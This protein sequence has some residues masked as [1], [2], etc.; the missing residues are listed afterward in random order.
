MGFQKDS[1][2]RLFILLL[3]ASS[4][5]S[6]AI[7]EGGANKLQQ[8]A[9]SA[10]SRLGASRKVLQAAGSGPCPIEFSQQDLADAAGACTS[11]F[12]QGTAPQ[13]SCCSKT[14]GI[15]G[16]AQAR[17]ANKTGNL[18]VSS[19]VADVCFQTLVVALKGVTVSNAEMLLATCNITTSRISAP[20][21]GTSLV[22]L[23]DFYFAANRSFPDRG[24]I[25][26][27]FRSTNCSACAN[28]KTERFLSLTTSNPE[29]DGLLA[30]A[31]C[32]ELATVAMVASSVPSI[33][34]NGIARCSWGADYAP[35]VQKSTCT[36]TP[37]QILDFSAVRRSC[38]P[39]AYHY[40]RCCHVMIGMLAQ[41]LTYRE[42]SK[43]GP[44]P[45]D[46][47]D[48]CQ[49]SFRDQL[50][51]QGVDPS[52]LDTCQLSGSYFLT[53]QACNEYTFY[54]GATFPSSYLT[55]L[56]AECSPGT[57]NANCTTDLIAMGS[58]LASPD[59]IFACIVYINIKYMAEQANLVEATDRLTC[60]IVLPDP[61]RLGVNETALAELN[62]TALGSLSR[63]GRPVGTK[64]IVALAVGGA[65]VVT[66]LVVVSAWLGLCRKK[67]VLGWSFY[68]QK[69]LS[70]SLSLGGSE[71]Y[72]NSQI[73]VYSYNELKRA[74][75]YFS[76]KRLLG[77]GG[78]GYVYLGD[79]P[80][81][82]GMVAVKKI[83][84]GRTKAG[85][86]EFGNE[87]ESMSRCRHKHL[88]QLLGVCVSDNHFVLVYEYMVNG[89]LEDHL[90]VPLA[91]AEKV[92]GRGNP[93]FLTWQMRLKIA[94]GTAKGLTYLHEDCSPKIIHRD[95]KPSNILLDKQFDAKVCDFGLAKFS[96]D[97]AT[98]ISTGIAGTW[99]YLAPE[100]VATSQLT[101]KSDVYSYGVVLL[102]LISGRRPTEA[103]L[104][105]DEVFLP[106][107]AWIVAEQGRLRCLVDPRLAADPDFEKHWESME[108]VLRIALFCVHTVVTTR[109]TM[110][111]CIAMLQGDMEVPTLPSRPMTLYTIGLVAT[112][113]SQTS[114]RFRGTAS[115]FKMDP[116]Q[117]FPV[118]EG[119]EDGLKTPQQSDIMEAGI[120][121]STE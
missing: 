52:I 89:S 98:H 30:T 57:C 13:G 113:H 56:E 1:C 103:G 96:D 40:E 26:S 84:V 107:Y 102:T 108:R 81:S 3:A 95:V 91:D 75:Q 45:Q 66:V 101:E 31:P 24:V 38:G 5:A 21:C 60:Y 28:A 62:A 17:Y 2:L 74:T 9:G 55:E 78:S 110:R 77:R 36:A 23:R 48:A 104:P 85:S 68:E 121:W 118:V 32:Q 79:L 100:Y 92:E 64:L 19:E 65:V 69:S 76:P 16:L 63:S 39:E 10:G 93:V 86:R 111:Q 27:C 46:Q 42:E 94:V 29:D 83:V 6:L 97:G 49:Q 20:A 88:V 14:A 120:S 22:T 116:V 53:P 15:L 12:A 35:L 112:G 59:A 80:R 61:L 90:Y 41:I 4:A 71:N 72:S 70:R 8:L 106:E 109:P 73:I 34:G 67:K 43:A 33:V 105:E 82:G 87:V 99:G 51:Q 11:I 18:L 44:L 119:N 114:M 54:N 115:F 37:W 117:E 50:S 25:N 7:V 47:L 58:E